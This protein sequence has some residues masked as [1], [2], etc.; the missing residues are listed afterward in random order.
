MKHSSLILLALFSLFSLFSLKAFSERIVRIE[1]QELQQ[2][3]SRISFRG[4]TAI[5]HFSEGDS[6]DTPCLLLAIEFT[7]ES[8]LSPLQNSRV[9]LARN[10]V[11]ESL[12][13]ENLE[14]GSSLL[15]YDSEG[16]L[17]KKQQAHASSEQIDL[18]GL[19]AAVYLL[20]TGKHLI[21][22]VK[23]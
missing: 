21:R 8:G 10:P 14:V 5:L 16:R 2:A 11:K 23:Q 4:D 1:G 9:L 13:L 12:V 15:L 3:V 6:L 22:F 17:I 7:D 19:P 20:R 18:S